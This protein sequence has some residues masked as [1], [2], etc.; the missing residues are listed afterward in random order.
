MRTDYPGAG[1]R[2][3]AL[4]IACTTWAIRSAPRGTAETLH[5]DGVW[6]IVEPLAADRVEGNLHPVG[7]VLYAASTMICVPASLAH[8]GPAVGAQAG[9]AACAK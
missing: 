2:L 4:S 8:H 7:R 9:E 5:A 1:L 3:V 6:M